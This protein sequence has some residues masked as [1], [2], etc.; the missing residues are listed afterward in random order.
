MPDTSPRLPFEIDDAIDPALV[1]GRAGVPLVIELFRQ[2]GVA[3]TIDAEV[4]IKQRQRG[5]TRAQL[6]E[7]LI[8][9]WASGGCLLGARGVSREGLGQR[10][11]PCRFRLAQADDSCGRSNSEE[12]KRPGF[13][14]GL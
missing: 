1:T 2:L 13:R 4:V 10:A 12:H 7:S 8:V 9:L 14:I 5:L 11:C 6:V 3:Q